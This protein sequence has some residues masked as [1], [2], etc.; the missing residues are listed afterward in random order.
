MRFCRPLLVRLSGG[1]FAVRRAPLLVGWRRWSLRRPR[2]GW[3]RRGRARGRGPLRCLPGV[4]RACAVAGAAGLC[5]F[6]F[7]ARRPLRLR[8]PPRLSPVAWSS[9][10]STPRWFLWFAFVVARGRLPRGRGCARRGRVRRAWPG[11]L[12][13]RRGRRIGGGVRGRRRG[14]PVIRL[15]R[16]WPR[17]RGCSR[18]RVV[19]LWRGRGGARG[20]A[21]CVVG[22]RPRVRSGARPFGAAVSG[23]CARVGR[24]GRALACLSRGPACARVRFGRVAVVWFGLM[25]VRVRGCSAWRPCGLF[26][27]LRWHAPRVGRRRVGAGFSGRCGWVAL[28]SGDR[29]IFNFLIYYR[30]LFL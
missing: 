1:L 27:R 21:R 6:R 24:G 9:R 14:V 8:C 10:A 2:L 5:P 3:S 25:G 15:R 17:W 22:G 28:A 30:F 23:L 12:R 11:R 18:A 26:P 4:R 19:G 16:F 13:V 20:R 29:A 7:R